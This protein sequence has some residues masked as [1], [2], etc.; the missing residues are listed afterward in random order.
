MVP[1][2]LAEMTAT[3]PFESLPITL[4]Q[5]TSPMSTLI[6]GSFIAVAATV[7][8]APF[9]LLAAHATAEPAAFQAA[10]SQPATA[11]QLGLALIVA[12]GFVTVPLHLLLRRWQQPR[13]IIVSQQSVSAS[14][15]KGPARGN[16]NE[17]LS[18]YQG[19]THHIRT[20]LSGAQHE[21]ILVHAQPAK[22]VV[23]HV[24]DRIGQPE[25]EAIARL[26]NVP[27]VPTRA[28][29]ERHRAQP[30]DLAQAA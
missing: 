17:P 18:A 13:R 30:L 7:L 20:S 21:I 29:Y 3:A 1:A 27:Q 5:S 15:A 4:E 22:S 24:A 2:K 28:L 12:L 19:V 14:D 8:L 26:L 10:I 25:I 23:L 9:G 11:V 16:W 6:I